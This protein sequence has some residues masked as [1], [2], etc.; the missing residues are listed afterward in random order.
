[1]AENNCGVD[2]TVKIV[3]IGCYDGLQE[4]N[5]WGVS[6]DPNVNSGIFEVA[7]NG[8]NALEIN[9]QLYSS[10]GELV[11]NK[12]V[13]VSSESH[14]EKVNAGVLSS[15]VYIL[16]LTLSDSSVVKRIVISQD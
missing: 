7:F 8:I 16:K 13:T 14:V 3:D 12:A 6:V 2:S 11:F 10:T 9:I 5:E 1:M 15:G 4:L